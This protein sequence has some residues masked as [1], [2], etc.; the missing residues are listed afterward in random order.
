MTPI[1]YKRG[2]KEDSGNYRPVSLN[3]VTR[4]NME[5]IVQET[6]LRYMENREVVSDSQQ[7]FS[8]DKLCLTN[9]LSFYNKAG[10]GEVANV[11]SLDLCKAFDSV[12]Y[13][14]FI[15]K[16]EIHG[17]DGWIIQGIR[18]WLDGRTERVVVKCKMS[19]QRSVM[20]VNCQGSLLELVLFNKKL[21][22]TSA[23]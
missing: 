9:F 15:S 16:L 2:K 11:T 7:G 20:S 5:E 4:K 18:N 12:P 22:A 23:Y 21:S 10:K 8:E 17:F 1:F 6:I 13:N 14:I 3:S 19:R